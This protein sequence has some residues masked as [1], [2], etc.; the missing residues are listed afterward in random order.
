MGR[1]ERNFLQIDDPIRTETKWCEH[2]C[3]R[4]IHHHKISSIFSSTR[5]LFFTWSQPKDSTCIH[6]FLFTCARRYIFTPHIYRWQWFLWQIANFSLYRFVVVNWEKQSHHSFQPNDFWS[7]YI[8]I[9]FLVA[10]FK[11]I[12]CDLQTFTRQWKVN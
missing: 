1:K 11:R 3:L 10:S 8:R 7:H 6:C 12:W 4:R 2:V 9:C 5:N